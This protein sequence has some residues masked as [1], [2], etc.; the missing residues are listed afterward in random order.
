[1]GGLGLGLVG[2]LG[3]MIIQ[4]GRTDFMEFVNTHNRLDRDNPVRFQMGYSPTHGTGHARLTLS[5]DSAEL[6]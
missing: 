2:V 6:F 1:M 4:P 5:F 3:W